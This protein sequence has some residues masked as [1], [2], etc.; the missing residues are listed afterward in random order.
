M[1]E[2]KHS[3]QPIDHPSVRRVQDH[4]AHDYDARRDYI[5]NVNGSSSSEESS[6]GEIVRENVKVSFPRRKKRHDMDFLL[7]ELV[8]QQKLYLQSQRKVMKLKTE[9]DTEEVR[10]RYLKLDL[11]NA[12]VTSEEQKEKLKDMKNTLFYAR[13]EN[14]VSRLLALL[15]IMFNIYTFTTGQIY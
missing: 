15:L 1:S 5:N 12:Q 6:D 2:V 11:N 13:T 7:Q 4:L 8:A 14:W 10:T 3:N 9:I